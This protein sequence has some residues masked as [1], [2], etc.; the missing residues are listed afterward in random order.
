MSNLS[1]YNLRICLFSLLSAII[2]IHHPFV[3]W[4]SFHL[5][6]Y[7]SIYRYLLPSTYHL[8]APLPIYTFT[9]TYIYN[10]LFIH[11]STHPSISPPLSNH[12]STFNINT[13]L[14]FLIIS[15]TWKNICITIVHLATTMSGRESIEH[16]ISGQTTFFLFFLNF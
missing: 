8:S 11:L 13:F 5:S 6:A 9:S 14:F 1:W 3:Y 15:L 7:P 16:Q 4:S 10:Y 12:L 2:S